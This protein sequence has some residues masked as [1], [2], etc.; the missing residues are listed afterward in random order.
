MPVKPPVSE[1]IALPHSIPELDVSELANLRDTPIL[2]VRSPGEF[3]KGHISCAKNVPLFSDEE[4]SEIGTLYKQLSSEAAIQRGTT[5]AIAKANELL[6][7]VRREVP[8]GEFVIHCWRG[9]MRSEGFSRL[10]MAHGLKPRRL[11]GGYKSFRQAV[12]RS[13]SRP[14]PLVVVTGSTGCGKTELLNQL[15]AAGEQVID[16]ES[17]AS[18]KGS[19]FGG[20]CQPEQ[21]TVEQ[22][23]N[24]LF[25]VCQK[26]RT[27]LP[28]WVEDESRSIGRIQLPEA[29][30]NCL[31]NAPAVVMNSNTQTRVDRLVAQYG[32]LPREELVAAIG[33]LRKRLGGQRF[34][35]ATSFVEQSRIRE[36]I[37]LILEYYDKAYAKAL[38]AR[39][40][41]QV[42]SLG[43]EM[44]LGS[45]ALQAL[46]ALG[47]RLVEPSRRHPD[48]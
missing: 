38:A 44:P 46:C 41:I 43:L 39:P 45:D 10:C 42:D 35:A 4:R 8:D 3:L 11:V 12:I 23:E 29:F 36:A 2:D 32:R 48:N 5:I 6:R 47:A 40:G 25:E 30:W 37:T 19:A 34:Q 14:L 22:F 7:L 31:S 26:L 9:G 17:L 16:L 28:I 33:R 18:H 1:P 13:F 27:D 24:H 15:Q 21:P 20:I